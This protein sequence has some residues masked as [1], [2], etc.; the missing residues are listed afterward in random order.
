MTFSKSLAAG[1]S[2][3][4]NLVLIALKIVVG[5]ITGS[6]AIISE[7]LHS[8]MDLVAA[9]VAFVSVRKAD[10]PAD[11]EHPYGHA[12]L[13]HLAAAFE[14]FLLIVASLVIVVEAIRRLQSGA[15]VESIGLGI[16]VIL[17]SI[18]GSALVASFLF[19]QAR[20]HDSPALH[21]DATHLQADSISSVAVLV[22]LILVKI[23][24]NSTFDSIVAIVIAVWIAFTGSR[25]TWRSVMDLMDSAPPPEEMDAIEKLIASSRPVEMVGY[26]KL[27]ARKA[28]SRRYVEMHV[29]FRKGTT[30][31]RAHELAHELRDAI[32]AQVERS[33]VLIHVEPETSVK[34]RQAESSEGPFRSG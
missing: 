14:G 16:G 21:G 34:E 31:E 19:R 3:L 13:E 27:R 15:E 6:V 20:R 10:E 2:I 25:I 11:E 12:K 26:H 33:E 24:G 23:T 28:G 17:F 5:V 9:V 29:Q 4:Y 30:L 18:V 8:I 7:A 1:V 22:G 32:E